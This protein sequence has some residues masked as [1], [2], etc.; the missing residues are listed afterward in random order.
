MQDTLLAFVKKGSD[1]IGCKNEALYEE[2]SGIS[3]TRP[4]ILIY[5]RVRGRDGGSHD[6]GGSPHLGSLSGTC[7]DGLLAQRASASFSIDHLPP[8]MRGCKLIG[9]D[10]EFVSYENVQVDFSSD[11]SSRI[12]KPQK[13]R[14][15]RLSLVDADCC[16]EDEGRIDME[17]QGGRLTGKVLLDEFVALLPG[18]EIAD[19]CSAFSGIY[20]GDLDAQVSKYRLTTRK[21]GL[22]A[23]VGA[24]R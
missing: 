12:A 9:V 21:V 5:D 6:G 10:A 13:M 1:W 2:R 23:P 24:A 19:Y 7:R 11:G 22:S 16:E 20:P 14:L 3:A 8:L 17:E 4:I 18:E 15:A